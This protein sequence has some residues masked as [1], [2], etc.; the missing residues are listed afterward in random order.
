MKLK[1]GVCFGMQL[2]QNLTMF[3]GGR[4]KGR[5]KLGVGIPRIENCDE[6]IWQLVVNDSTFVK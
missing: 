3:W 4:A 6:F 2:Q 5:S 1:L